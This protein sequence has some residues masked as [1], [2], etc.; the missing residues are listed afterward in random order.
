MKLTF[1]PKTIYRTLRRFQKSSFQAVR[2]FV[3][4]Y[5]SD[6]LQTL[7]KHSLRAVTTARKQSHKEHAFMRRHNSEIS[8]LPTDSSYMFIGTYDSLMHVG[9]GKLS[10]DPEDIRSA[11]QKA[12][13]ATMATRE[14]HPD[15]GDVS[16]KLRTKY[17]TVSIEGAKL[18]HGCELKEVEKVS[19]VF[20]IVCPEGVDA[21][22]VTA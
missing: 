19:K 17:F 3:L 1:K 5:D 11:V 9:Y 18:A 22:L 4:R 2:F 21:E 13:H 8:A 16:Y 6:H 15:T 14:V 10:G 7:D 12:I 20:E